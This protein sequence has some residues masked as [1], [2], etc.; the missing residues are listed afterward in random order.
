MDRVKIMF[1]PM[2]PILTGEIVFDTLFFIY[3]YQSRMS[4]SE[5]TFTYGLQPQEHSGFLSEFT[6]NVSFLYP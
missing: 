4:G 2:C 5:H 3:K 6:G 1:Y